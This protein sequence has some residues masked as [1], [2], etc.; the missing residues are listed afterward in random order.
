M[1][2]LSLSLL[3]VLPPSLVWSCQ[4]RPAERDEVIALARNVSFMIAPAPELAALQAAI[5]G[6]VILPESPRYDALRAVF[7]AR[8]DDVRPQALVRCKTTA[9]VVETIALARRLELPTATRSGGHCFAGRSTGP[10]I[11]IDVTPMNSVSVSADVATVG[12]GARLGDI[13]DSLEDAGITIAGGCGPTVGIAGLTLGGGLGILGRMYGLTSDH[14]RAAQTV[15]ADGRVL[16]CDEQREADLFWALRGA[17]NGN[18]GVATSLVFDTRA[19]PP[20]TVL[21]L[22]WPFA[23]AA[24]VIEA[25]QAWAPPAP[26]ELAAS[27]LITAPAVADEAPTVIV[28]GAVAG[29]ESDANALL[30]ELVTRVGADPNSTTLTHHSYREAKRHLVD[31]AEG[32]AEPSRPLL[33]SKSEFFRDQLPPEAVTAL[34]ETLAASRRHGESRELD[35][36]PWGGAYNRTPADATAFVHRDAA[37]L[38][39]HAAVVESPGSRWVQRSHATAHAWG[40]GGVYPNFP[41]PDLPDPGRAYYGSN[42]SRLVRVKR[43]YDPDGFFVGPVGLTG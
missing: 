34:V 3:I 15:T 28:R 20:T 12:A 35:F 37:F 32:G 8:F 36:S 30:D 21:Q 40:T 6:E 41:D 16:E 38:L 7:N 31:L 13:Y 9:D 33:F 10:G 23:R 24:A 27:L 11:V 29:T 19:A 25:W 5:E 2:M 39:K 42:Y 26:D 4:Q 22:D 14:L 18:F 1:V 43:R 17:G